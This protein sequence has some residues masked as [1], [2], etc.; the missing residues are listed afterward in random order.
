MKLLFIIAALLFAAPALGG[1]PDPVFGDI[2]S[3]VATNAGLVAVSQTPIAQA[4]IVRDGFFAAGDGGQAV[5]NWSASA[6]SLN[7]GAGDNGSQ[8]APSSG[9]GCWL[10]AA[11]GA[12]DL[13]VWG[14]VA[15]D[16]GYD[17]APAVR[18][19]LAYAAASKAKIVAPPGG[20]IG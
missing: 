14:L 1:A 13:R 3:H 11:S 19:A 12:V 5:Y 6:C 9:T 4:S 15:D 18:A 20:S 17:N 10:L 7:S 8:V 16:A 2:P